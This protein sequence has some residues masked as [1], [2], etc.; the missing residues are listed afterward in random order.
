MIVVLWLSVLG[1]RM[2]ISRE[3][4]L[5]LVN[6]IDIDTSI[7]AGSYPYERRGIGTQ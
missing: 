6:G 2:S 4:G 7:I 1:W 3:I 5:G